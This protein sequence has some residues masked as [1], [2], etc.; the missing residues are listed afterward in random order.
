MN[1]YQINCHHFVGWIGLLLNCIFYF[2]FVF[3]FYLNLN[4]FKTIF[5]I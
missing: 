3:H 4:N 5:N 1:V 2:L